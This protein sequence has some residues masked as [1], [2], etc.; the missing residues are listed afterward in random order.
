[1]MHIVFVSTELA[2][3]TPG[4]AGG[5]VS[6][7]RDRLIDRGDR[8]SV[9]LV[10]D[11]DGDP[12]PGVTITGAGATFE[13]RSKLAAHAVR[14][15]VAIDR[16]D[17]IEFQDFDG[18]AFESLLLRTETGI[19]R[20]PTQVRFHGPA[21]LM[22]EAIGV[23]PPEIAIARTMEEG[24][25]SMA[26][27]VVVPS[28]G[29]A[30]LVAERYDVDIARVRV[31]QPPLPVPAEVQIR[32]AAFPLIVS[33]GRL[34]EVKGS[35]DLIAAAVPV[36]RDHPTVRLAL[37]GEDGW[38]AT[39]GKPMSRW[40]S[41]DLIPSDVADQ[42]EVVGRLEA[43]ALAQ[44]I[45]RAWVVVVASRFE[46]FNLAVHEARSAGLPVIVPKLVAFDG[47][48]NADTGAL[49][50]DG[51][52]QGLTNALNAIVTDPVLRERLAACPKPKYTDPMDPYDSPPP[53]RHTREQ[54]GLATIAV[55]KLHLVE[56]PPPKSWSPEDDQR[57]LPR[58]AA[59]RILMQVP[60]SIAQ[61]AVSAIPAKRRESYGFVADWRYETSK[62]R[63]DQAEA[64]RQATITTERGR[65]D[66][67]VRNGEFPD[68][69]EPLVSVIIPCHND[70]QFLDDAIRSVFN[71]TAPSFEVLVVDDGS[72]DA[73]TIE[74]LDTLAWSRTR[75]I[76]QENQGLSAARNTGMS[77][78]LGEFVVPLD[79]DDQLE[80][81]FIETLAGALANRPDAAFA[82]CRAVLFGDIN[83]VWIPR[84]YNPYQL[85]LSNSVVGCVLLRR[86][87]YNDVGGYDEGLR[88]GNED[89][90][91]WV[92]LMERG[93]SQVDV[94]DVLFRYR[95]H[96]ISM[97]VTTEARFEKGRAEIVERHPSIYAR[98]SMV[99]LKRDNY[100]LVSMLI[101]RQNDVASI[102]G[103][104]IDDAEIIV[105]EDLRDLIDPVARNRDWPVR[106]A[107]SLDDAI[108]ASHAKFVVHWRDVTCSDPSVITAM[109]NRIESDPDLG[110]VTTQGSDPLQLVRR[111]SLLDPQAPASRAVVQID[112]SASMQLSPG[113]H[114]DPDWTIERDLNG[115]PVQRQRPEEE[116]R[117]PSWLP[118]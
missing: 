37:I 74:I 67:R 87:A 1:M 115:I 105:L 118:H 26:D 92:R 94:P 36:L 3:L 13:E 6:V 107:A 55:Q 114:P 57:S 95:K 61:T 39:A 82:A 45:S 83:A 112:G 51:S 77:A 91:L 64:V 54:S 109:A 10:A 60:E 5:L 31:G 53:V 28:P 25:F 44:Y 12:P 29:I 86:S 84:P 40:L 17:L 50:Y 35:H 116:G 72:T 97:S 27:Q 11:H 79:A 113:G 89:W 103:Q 9:I 46:S 88:N 100:P 38:S 96:G 71:Q 43:D 48:L 78:A 108:S 14:K 101:T 106:T 24:A 93:W 85:L 63:D 80:P 56:P 69:A 21:D 49:V 102:A 75:V 62:R 110:A 8:V 42:V 59:T 15:L 30:D 2:P 47:I 23:E 16:P 33:V 111:W 41:E 117:I 76:H 19:D 22:F 104:D 65:L 7:L 66:D 4:G 73:E 68:L 70:G 32:P 81:R 90:D 98:D 58:R 99:A 52:H 20:I 34:G 18:L